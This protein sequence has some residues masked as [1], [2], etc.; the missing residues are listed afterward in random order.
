MVPLQ[1]SVLYDYKMKYIYLH[2]KYGN[3]LR[4]IVDDK[5][6]SE[7]SKYRWHLN[8]KGYVLRADYST[9]VERAVRM[10]NQIMHPPQG[11]QVDHISRDRLD[12][13][14]CNLRIC[15]PGENKANCGFYKS[16]TSG[17]RGVYAMPNGRWR[18]RLGVDGRIVSLG[19]YT[20][21]EDARTARDAAAQAYH[22]EFAFINSE[23]A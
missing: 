20:S 10:H 23:A 5:D 4:A 14:R 3:G 16:N 6:Y 21:R 22:K 18:A 1:A 17:Y 13:R 2:G 12:N 15:T 7:L 19:V 9:G 11:R 8:R